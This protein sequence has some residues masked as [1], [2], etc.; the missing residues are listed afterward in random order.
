[1]SGNIWS[2][3]FIWFMDTIY[4]KSHSFLKRPDCCGPAGLL[5]FPFL[6]ENYIVLYGCTLP[7]SLISLQSFLGKMILHGA[8]RGRDLD[9]WHLIVFLLFGFHWNNWAVLCC[10]VCVLILYLPS[11]VQSHKS[12]TGL[13][14]P[15]MLCRETANELSL[16]WRVYASIS[17]CSKMQQM[18]VGPGE[19]GE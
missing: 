19:G 8:E 14:M 5:K 16:L 12:K 11:C 7:L 18:D 13:V 9:M 3:K 15:S 1:M 10:D 17:R 6:C 4:Y 2:S